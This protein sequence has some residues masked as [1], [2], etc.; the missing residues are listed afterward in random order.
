MP[1]QHFPLHTINFITL[2]PKNNVK[3]HKIEN[4]TGDRV[5]WGCEIEA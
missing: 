3:N 2:A 1:G 4:E 5:V